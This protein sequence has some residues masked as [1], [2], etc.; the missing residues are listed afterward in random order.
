MRMGSATLSLRSKMSSIPA[1]L[2]SWGEGQ[3]DLARQARTIFQVHC[4]RCHGEKGAVEGGF[5]YL[6]DHDRLVARKK[7]VPG[8]PV[9]SRLIRRIGAGEMPPEDEKKR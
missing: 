1:C 4:Y 7:V 8:D 3:K 2:T 6:L 9:K 5:N